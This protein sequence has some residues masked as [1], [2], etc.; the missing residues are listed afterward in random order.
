[1]SRHELTARIAYEIYRQRGGA[2]GRHVEDWLAAEA[3]VALCLAFAEELLARER[4][5]AAQ[6][7]EQAAAAEPAGTEAPVEAPTQPEARI[8]P[9]PAPEERA[10]ALLQEAVAR[11]SRAEVAEQLGYK[12]AGSLGRYL[13]GDRPIGESLAARILAAL[14]E[15]PRRRKRAA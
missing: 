2:P 4:P 1:M 13:R 9:E 12:S 8:L 10:L 5:A 11:T 3:I 7:G 14:A 15:Q 6:P